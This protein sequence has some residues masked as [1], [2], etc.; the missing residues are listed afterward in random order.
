MLVQRAPPL[1]DPSRWRI[2][3]IAG[4]SRTIAQ[5]VTFTPYAAAQPCSARCRFCSENLRLPDVG[6]AASMLRPGP[7]Y[8][9]NLDAAL[10]DLVELPLGFSL[11][12]LEMT[13]DTAWFCRMGAALAAHARRSTVTETVLY[14]NGAGLVDGA[15]RDA[16]LT[17]LQCLPEVSLE[18]S[19][20][21]HDATANQHIMRFREGIDIAGAD[22]FARTL[23]AVREVAQ[24]KLVCVVQRG[25]IDSGAA[26]L[27]YL[28]WAADLG[29]GTVIFRELSALDARYSP[30]ATARYVESARCAVVDLVNSSREIFDIRHTTLGYYFWNVCGRV[31]GID[32]VFEASDYSR[33]HAQHDSGRVYKL[34]LHANG[35]LCAGWNPDRD[36]LRPAIR[37]QA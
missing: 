12:G 33:M 20:H 25:G 34:V 18:W 23:K 11:S 4:A 10:A 5:P 22:A 16:V 19:R 35:N 2:H 3:T 27:D 1:D 32:V 17:T 9:E 14:T 8:F 7:D 36:V 26:V 13:D 6:R 31:E 37:T 21:H 29:I 30:N 28:H 24:V 15:R